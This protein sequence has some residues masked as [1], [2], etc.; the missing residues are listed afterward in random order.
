MQSFWRNVLPHSITAQ[1]TII[2]AVSVVVGVALV[3]GI[4][5]LFFDDSAK[6]K[7]P[8]VAAQIGSISLMVQS[9]STI[10]EAEAIVAGARRVGLKVTLAAPSEIGVPAKAPPPWASSLLAEKLEVSWGLDVIGNVAAPGDG[11][12]RL[13]IGV[14]NFG[15]LLFDVSS[16]TSIWP[17][18]MVPTMLTLAIVLVFVTLLSVYAV[19]WIIAPL[20]TLAAAAHSFGRVPDDGLSVTRR[21]PQEIASVADALDEM[22]T[23]IRALIDDR[24]RM[25]TAI[26]HDLYTPLT[27]L[28]LR[29]ERVS[30]VELRKGIL[31]EVEQITR[32]L[33]E[34]LDYLRED[35][36]SENISRVDLPSI[37]QTI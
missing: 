8:V 21:S 20:R 23:R 33:D 9:A 15:V 2:V 30:D 18:L 14:G 1:I 24:T 29:A 5:S 36:R 34:T 25:L 13:A 12:G 27:R 6:H 17:Y 4:I 11:T 3:V 37:L 10:D 26:S 31:H 32:M 22:R 35:V 16:D 19:R 7:P 28:G